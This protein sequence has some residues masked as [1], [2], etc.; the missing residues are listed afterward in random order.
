MLEAGQTPETKT[1]E[2][3]TKHSEKKQTPA[4]KQ[5]RKFL[6]NYRLTTPTKV[7]SSET[8][9]QQ[10][11]QY[12]VSRNSAMDEMMLKQKIQT[13]ADRYDTPKNAEAAIKE[14]I[15][16]FRKTILEALPHGIDILHEAT[17]NTEP[18]LKTFQKETINNIHLVLSEI[19]NLSYAYEQ[20]E[21]YKKRNPQL[22]LNFIE[23][24]K[25]SK[26]RQN[27]QTIN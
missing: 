16:L 6:S 1:T 24:E 21:H 7:N 15:A 19:V 8:T 20:S 25:Q 5:S 3:T 22:N 26:I 13:L 2:N 9:S 14:T 17:R 10:M 18:R 12:Y 4:D 11:D 27:I 23:E